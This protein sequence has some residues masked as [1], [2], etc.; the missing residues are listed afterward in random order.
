MKRQ[1]ALATLANIAGYLALMQADARY[2]LLYPRGGLAML[3]IS[4]CIAWI[5]ILAAGR[6]HLPLH[7]RFQCAAAAWIW[8][9]VQ[10][11]GLGYSYYSAVQG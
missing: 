8:F 5:G 2:G 9:L 4:L 11:F 1:A 3:C 7:T 10:G 6:D